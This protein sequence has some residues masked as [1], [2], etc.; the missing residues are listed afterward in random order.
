M[1]VLGLLVAG[2]VKA[3][4]PAVAP[5]AL[6]VLATTEA[7]AAV[8][9]GWSALLG[10]IGVATAVLVSSKATDSNP[11]KVVVPLKAGAVLP[12][13]VAQSGVPLV[14][15]TNT[16]C[17]TGEHPNTWLGGGIYTGAYGFA[18]YWVSAFART[19]LNCGTTYITNY[20]S[21]FQTPKDYE[22]MADARSCLAAS[23][24]RGGS[25]LS[26]YLYDMDCRS[27][28]P[29]GYFSGIVGI[30]GIGDNGGGIS[31]P[32]GYKVIEG[33]TCELLNARR[34]VSDKRCD[35]GRDGGKFT[36]LDD[37]DCDSV[38]GVKPYSLNGNANLLTSSMTDQDGRAF[39]RTVAIL[40]D[41]SEVVTDRQMTV[42][43]M[44]AAKL[45]YQIATFDLN[46]VLRT[47]QHFQTTETLT[48]GP[49]NT[50]NSTDQNGNPSNNTTG[51]AGTT[52]NVT[53]PSD[54][55]KDGTVAGIKDVLENLTKTETAPQDPTPLDAAEL[56]SQFFGG[57]FDGLLAWR[58]PPHASECATADLDFS[59]FGREFSLRLD[60]HCALAEK[61]RGA[62]SAIMLVAWSLGAL[63]IVLRA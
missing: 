60:S 22:Q 20:W 11:V 36:N 56:K 35:V 9:S 54:Y 7:G 29:P 5:L 8:A 42:D 59:L 19:N 53:F 3:F 34:A 18:W 38:A 40:G 52:V 44:N 4:A 57:T 47:L 33:G 12:P 51:Q 32:A 62:M 61:S 55:A 43:E 46:A 14:C 24:L 15:G 17:A 23:K 37:V 31:C 2:S 26:L 27:C 28:T 49:N 48:L 39:A 45:D 30:D 13:P 41:G 58:L 25:C 50:A 16:S 6:E 21:C 10:W 1:F 63:F